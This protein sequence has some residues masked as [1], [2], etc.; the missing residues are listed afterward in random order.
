[1][2]EG[3]KKWQQKLRLTK[4]IAFEA[5]LQIAIMLAFFVN[6]YAPVNAHT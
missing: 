1:M 3:S 2:T 4:A 5:V 6:F